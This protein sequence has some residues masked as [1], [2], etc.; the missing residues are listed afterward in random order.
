MDHRDQR[1]V[2][3]RNI[4]HYERLLRGEL[5]DETRGTIAALL[6]EARRELLWHDREAETP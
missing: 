3:T 4:E 1:F 5:D 6:K 2:I